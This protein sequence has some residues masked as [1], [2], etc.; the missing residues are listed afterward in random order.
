MPFYL[1]TGKALAARDT[2][3]AIHFKQAP[4]ALFQRQR[5]SRPAANTLVLQIQPRRR[6]RAAIRG[7]AARTGGEVRAGA[8]GLPLR[9]FFHAAPS[10]GYETLIY[11]CLIGD[12][13]LFKRADDDRVRLARGAAF[14]GRLAA[15]AGKSMA[16][17]PARTGRPAADA[18]LARDGRAWREI[19]P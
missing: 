6:H 16:T 8:D 17:R 9:R 7:Q 5:R 1:R 10:T 11:D 19:G 4:G 2:E 18:L 3:I 14:P 12:K 15:T 13:T